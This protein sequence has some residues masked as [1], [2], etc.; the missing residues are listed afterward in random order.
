M[1]RMCPTCGHQTGL[2]GGCSACGVS[3]TK[4]TVFME[5]LVL[6]GILIGVLI[7]MGFVISKVSGNPFRI[8]EKLGIWSFDTYEVT[9]AFENLPVPKSPQE[10][11]SPQRIAELRKL[12][13]NDQ[14]ESLNFIYENYQQDFEDDFNNE[15]KLQDAFRVFD[16]TLP[17]YEALF[18]AWILDSPDHFA[19]YLA[20]A[21]YYYAKAW[22]SW[23]HGAAKERTQAQFKMRWENFQKAIDDINIALAF[24]Q[25]LLTAYMM[26]I[27]ISTTLADET[28]LRNW[29]KEA[30]ELFPYSFLIRLQ[31]IYA[32]SPRGVGNYRKMEDFA[33]SAEHYADVNPYF[34]CLYGIIY[35]EQANVLRRKKRYEEAVALYTKAMAFGDY[36]YFYTKRAEAFYVYLK[37]LDKALAD[38]EYSIY[39]RPTIEKNY[40]LRSRI[41]FEKE[42]FE[43]AAYDLKK[44][45]DLG[46]KEACQRYKQYKNQ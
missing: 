27:K 37:D 45:C 26:L 31:Y 41:H 20:R 5:A 34:V 44:S 38:V 25:K 2:W 28:D 32:I 40:H 18:A 3:T 43:A 13:E 4:K 15:Y 14:F 7:V 11:I 19:P 8:F 9:R 6:T 46:N 36:W 12:F 29:A 35:C 10:T 39:L 24:N 16:T 1:D 23:G 30:L 17:S 21:H 22:E 42:D 33:R